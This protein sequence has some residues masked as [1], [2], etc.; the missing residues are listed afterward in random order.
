L[1]NQAG[2]PL[3][4]REV[5][6]PFPDLLD[7]IRSSLDGRYPTESEEEPEA[8]T[9]APRGIRIALAAFVPT[10][11]LVV[12]GLPHLLAPSS[13][14]PSPTP[15]PASARSTTMLGPSLPRSMDRSGVPLPDFIETWVVSDTWANAAPALPSKPEGVEPR[16][17]KSV[18][19][20]AVSWVRAAAFADNRAATR[21][22]GTMRSQGY[23]VD[24]RLEDSTTL[25]WVVWISKSPASSR[26]PK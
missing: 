25:P 20:D 8:E 26:S 1:A 11:L 3:V 2:G 13:A 24:L 14:P 7:D 23:R 10:F 4:E 18:S 5:L 17:V 22:A 6:D 21:L 12:I 19:V 16:P 9:P 15:M